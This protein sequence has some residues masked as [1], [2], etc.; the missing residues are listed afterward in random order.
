[1]GTYT[2]QEYAEIYLILSEVPRNGAATVRFYMDRYPKCRLP[3]P[4][5]MALIVTSGTPVAFSL[6]E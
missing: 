4:H 5:F 3:N 2:F 1:M 6:L